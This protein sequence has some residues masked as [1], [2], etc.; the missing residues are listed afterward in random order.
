MGRQSPTSLAR[1]HLLKVAREYEEQGYR[2]LRQPG[3]SD[4]PDSLSGYQPDLIA[5]GADENVVVVVE[6]GDT[7]AQSDYLPS[8][9]NAVDTM[10]GWRFELIVTNDRN[11]SVADENAEELDQRDIQRR[12]AQVRQLLDN[13]Q[14]DDIA[15]LL[16]WTIVEAAMR[17]LARREAIAL[18]RDQP[19]LMLTKLYSLGLVS[20]EEYDLFGKGLHFRN[21]I[22]HGYRSPGSNEDVA[23]KMIDKVAELL[24]VG[25]EHSAG[26]DRM[27]V[28]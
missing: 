2:V 13:G 12:I 20:R 6:S 1:K 23:G 26:Q 3:Q 19:T 16:A 14:Q 15:A 17:L 28:D 25:V 7:L 4:L 21:L 9:A 24:K 18:E 27:A 22:V 5:Y 8:L 10:P 11:A